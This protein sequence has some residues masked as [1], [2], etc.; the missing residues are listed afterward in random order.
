MIVSNEA[1]HNSSRI[2][3]GFGAAI[4]NTKNK[5]GCKKTMRAEWIVHK[6]T[7]SNKGKRKSHYVDERTAVVK[8]TLQLC[9]VF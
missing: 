8:S 3:G 7:C 1:V 5:Y 2:A 4:E 9:F 6:T